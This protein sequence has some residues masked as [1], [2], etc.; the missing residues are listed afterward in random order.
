LG[1]WVR[2]ATSRLRASGI[3]AAGLEARVLAGH[4]VGLEPAEVPLARH[5]ALSAQELVQLEQ[6]LQRRQQG[7]PIAY[8]VGKAEF[9]S[10]TLEV[11]PA[12][13]IPRPETEHLVEVAL[14]A[15][16]RMPGPGDGT[17]YLGADLGTGSGAIALALLSERD[18]LEMFAV[19]ASQAALAVARRN[20]RRCGLAPRVTFMA[21]NWCE[22]LLSAGLA[23]RLDLVVSNP[24]YVA[25]IE[26]EK[27][28]SEVR[29]FEPPLALFGGEDG[30]D[31]Y[32]AI[33]ADVPRLLRP[34]GWLAFE[35]APA[36]ASL[37][38]DLIRATG[39][40][41]EPELYTDYA[42]RLRVVGAQRREAP[43]GGGSNG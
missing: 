2:Q 35:V 28:P 38:A 31:A 18:D 41:A 4:V 1:Q 6:L 16:A 7:E 9:W 42:G 26:A 15:L 25:T 8:L 14:S 17:R 29:D 12:V 5:R 37:V 21:G 30:C 19:D 33:L 34:G 13:L 40:F 24:P 20:A 22:P 27:L 43:A 23:G 39:C 32:R 10:L 36:R 11:T 3:E